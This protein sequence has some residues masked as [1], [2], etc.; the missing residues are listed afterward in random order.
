MLY[1]RE[2]GFAREKRPFDRTPRRTNLAE[3]HALLLQRRSTLPRE[4]RVRFQSPLGSTIT[5]DRGALKRC[6]D[7]EHMTSAP[8]ALRLD[9]LG[10]FRGCVHAVEASRLKV[11]G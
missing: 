11:I 7:E 5:R 9:D 3:R 1:L 4:D 8:A 2:E 10:E 6:M